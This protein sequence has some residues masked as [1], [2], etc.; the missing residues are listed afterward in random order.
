MHELLYLDILKRNVNQYIKLLHKFFKYEKKQ[1]NKEIKNA[2]RL[3]KYRAVKISESIVI[4]L[5]MENEILDINDMVTMEML[6]IYEIIKLIKNKEDNYI[7]LDDKEISKNKLSE[8]Q[9]YLDDDISKIDK[10][11]LK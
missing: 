6:R 7:N 4:K 8:H 2:L 9:R 5:M 10:L 3:E 1:K 11:L